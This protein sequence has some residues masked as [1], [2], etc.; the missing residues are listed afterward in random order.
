MISNNQLIK[1]CK[2]GKQSAFRELY[3]LYASPML[4]VC[5][6]YSKSRDDAE[7]ILQEGFIK[8]FQ[9]IND[10][11]GTGVFEGWLRRIMVNTAINHYKSNLKYNFHDELKDDLN[12]YEDQGINSIILDEEIPREQL[13]NIIQLLPN[14][15]RMVF[16]MFV[17][18]GLTHKEIADELAIS[19]NTSKSQLSKAR[20]MLRKVITEKYGA[21]VHNMI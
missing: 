13:L 21:V 18:D 9:K 17:F 8:V 1:R 3:D 12:G 11:K 2:E 15:Y 14:G 6:R 10:F 20:K 4:G 16:N 7:D 5:F 19:E